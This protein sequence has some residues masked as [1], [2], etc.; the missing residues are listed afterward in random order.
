MNGYECEHHLQLH[1]FLV[2]IDIEEANLLFH[3]I[4]SQYKGEYQEDQIQSH[5]DE[6]QY[7]L[8][9]LLCIRRKEWFG[10]IWILQWTIGIKDFFDKGKKHFRWKD[11]VFAVLANPLWR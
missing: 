1:L 11:D 8:C 10:E 9:S 4:Q 3:H 6:F 2:H 5:W 7:I